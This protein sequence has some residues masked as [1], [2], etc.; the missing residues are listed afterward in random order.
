[1]SGIDS[2]PPPVFLRRLG[3]DE[4]EAPALDEAQR[5]AVRKVVAR[6][7]EDAARAGKALGDYWSGR[8]GTAAGLR[9]INEE[10]G[11]EFF[12]VPTEATMDPQAADEVF[13]GTDVVID[14]HTHFMADRPW[15][16]TVAEQ[17]LT[18]Y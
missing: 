14:V 5:R 15:L 4:F 18:S 8:L 11:Q 10:A 17:Q 9:A 3:T 12:E 2:N 16:H 6:G 13:T 7:P 1:M